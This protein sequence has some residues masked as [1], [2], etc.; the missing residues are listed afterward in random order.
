MFLQ[1]NKRKKQSFFFKWW[2]IRNNWD[3]KFFFFGACQKETG[4]TTSAFELSSTDCGSFS[5]VT[6]HEMKS[7]SLCVCEWRG[8]GPSPLSSVFPLSASWLS[9]FVSLL[10][11]EIV[12][13][14]SNYTTSKTPKCKKRRRRRLFHAHLSRLILQIPLDFLRQLFS[15]PVAVVVV[16]HLCEL[17]TAGRRCSYKKGIFSFFLSI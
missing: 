4:W 12:P 16:V 6:V 8:R 10:Q 13:L 17:I 14:S 9:R 15:T 11:F 1:E 5:N 7:V 2:E 3:R